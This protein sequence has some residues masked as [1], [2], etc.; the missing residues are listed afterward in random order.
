MKKLRQIWQWIRRE[1]FFDLNRVY[2]NDFRKSPINRHERRKQAK[3]DR[4]WY[5]SFWN[6]I[7]WYKWQEYRGA[8]DSLYKRK[9]EEWKRKNNIE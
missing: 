7:P 2:K 8:L 9:L 5:S 3:E 1:L 6:G 4:C